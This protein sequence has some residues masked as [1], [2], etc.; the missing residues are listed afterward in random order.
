[1]ALVGEVYSDNAILAAMERGD[2][3]IDPF[4]LKRLSGTT[5]DVCVAPDFM[6]LKKI[7]RKRIVTPHD[8]RKVFEGPFIARTITEYKREFDLEDLGEEETGK[9][10][11]LFAPFERVLGHTIEFI[12]STVPGIT[13]EIRAKSTTE[14]WGASMVLDAGLGNPGYMN[15]WTVEII[16]LNDF[17]FFLPTDDE[18]LAQISFKSVLDPSPIKRT[19]YQESDNINELKKNWRSKNMLP[20]PLL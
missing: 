2:I 4:D 5:Y 9:R 7:P 11:I 8:P 15:S 14:R 19:Y 3:V 18:P 12:G 13:A 1:M 17:W 6:R 16:N 20:K 10:G